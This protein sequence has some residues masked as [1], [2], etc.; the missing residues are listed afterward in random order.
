MPLFRNL[1][2]S[3]A[4]AGFS[5]LHDTLVAVVALFGSPRNFYVAANGMKILGVETGV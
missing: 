2:K 4:P 1:E 3:L 5:Q